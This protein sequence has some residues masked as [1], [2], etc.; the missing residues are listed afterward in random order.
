MSDKSAQ[1]NNA[2]L[3]KA[4]AR[5][6]RISPRKM[7]LVT[8]LVKNLRVNDAL[9]QLHFTNKKGAGFLA[10]LLRSA[11]ANAEN[12]FSLNS[13]NLMIKSV[14]CDMGQTMKR[15]FPRARGSAFII[16]RKLSIVNVILEE[17]PAKAKSKARLTDN[18]TKSAK[19]PITQEGSAGVPEM[20]ETDMKAGK[21]IGKTSHHENEAGAVAE[22]SGVGH[23]QNK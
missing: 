13:E 2:K 6:L 9:T 5:G 10:N 16:R 18:R 17:V 14:T 21:S 4:S 23:Q 20:T 15:Y 1:Q 3:V 19:A 11:V 8:N 7:R 12:N 22:K